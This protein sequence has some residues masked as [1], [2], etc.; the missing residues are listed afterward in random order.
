MCVPALKGRAIPG[1]AGQSPSGAEEKPAQASLQ[2]RRGF[3]FFLARPFRAGTHAA[4]PPL[5]IRPTAKKGPHKCGPLIL[6]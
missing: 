1:F 6:L 5:G 3:V 2:P 4:K